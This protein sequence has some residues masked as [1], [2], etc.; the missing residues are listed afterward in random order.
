MFFSRLKVMV[1]VV[2]VEGKVLLNLRGDT[3]MVVELVRTT[4]MASLYFDLAS[5]QFSSI[6]AMFASFR[7][8]A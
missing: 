2:L 8:I 1:S 3:A 6:T 5:V 7:A 4:F